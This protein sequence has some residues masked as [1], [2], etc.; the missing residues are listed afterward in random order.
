ML[1]LMV[2]SVMKIDITNVLTPI[3][4]EQNGWD[5]TTIN[6]AVSIGGYIAIALGFLGATLALKKDI[7]IVSLIGLIGEAVAAFLCAFTNTLPAICVGYALGQAFYPLCLLSAI[8]YV[9]RWYMKRR[10]WALGIATAALPITSTIYLSWGS[11]VV[12]AVGGRAT[13]YGIFGGII[14]LVAIFEIVFMKT[15][16]EAMAY[17][18]TELFLQKKSLQ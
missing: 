2:C 8:T 18:R 1:V 13:F 17:I 5:R 15:T 16:P 6:T 14:I 12:A 10:G 7:K 11:S 4:Q 9:S 3:L